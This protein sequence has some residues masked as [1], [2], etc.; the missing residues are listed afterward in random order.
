M[1]THTQMM[2]LTHVCKGLAE[3]YVDVTTHAHKGLAESYMDITTHMPKGLAVS[4]VDDVIHACMQGLS[5][6][7]PD[8]TPEEAHQIMTP[9]QRYSKPCPWGV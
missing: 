9:L 4:Y 6:L 7:S 1:A 2:G 8:S 3:S 5:C